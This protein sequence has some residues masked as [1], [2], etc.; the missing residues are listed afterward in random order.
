MMKKGQSSRRNPHKVLEAMKIFSHKR[1][2]SMSWRIPVNMKFVEGFAEGQ[3]SIRQAAF[4]QTLKNKGGKLS[5]KIYLSVSV[6]A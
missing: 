5:H 1:Y 4:P 6:S 3:E 2:Y